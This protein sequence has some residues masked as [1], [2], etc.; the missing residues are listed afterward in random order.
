MNSA[1]HTYIESTSENLMVD[2]IKFLYTD[3]FKNKV[4][5]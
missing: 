3:S 4:M 2:K 1:S 5:L